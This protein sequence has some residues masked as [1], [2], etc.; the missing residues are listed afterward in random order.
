MATLHVVEHQLKNRPH[1]E[2]GYRACLG[3]LSLAKR[4]R[5]SRLEA[6]CARALAIHSPTYP[7]VG[8]ILEKGLDRQ[9]HQGGETETAA[10]PTHANVRGPGYYNRNPPVTTTTA[11]RSC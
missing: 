2:H 8:S 1:P 5:R 3:L 11:R 6:A 7:S 10:L 4:Y 9:P